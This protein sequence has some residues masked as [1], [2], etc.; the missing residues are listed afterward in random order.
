MTEIKAMPEEQLDLVAGG[1][2]IGLASGKEN[3]NEYTTAEL[4]RMWDVIKQQKEWEFKNREM[5]DSAKKM[6]LDALLGEG[7]VPDVLNNLI[8]NF[9]GGGGA[10]GKK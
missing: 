7:A 6:W 9:I 4:N 10:G 2:N 3:T 5:E 1:V 8:P